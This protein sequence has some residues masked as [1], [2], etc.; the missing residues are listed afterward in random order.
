MQD[1]SPELLHLLLNV[2][3]TDLRVQL[4]KVLKEEEKS[5]TLIS[6]IDSDINDMQLRNII[7]YLSSIGLVRTYINDHPRTVSITSKGKEILS[8]L[9]K[10]N[11]LIW[12]INWVKQRINF[13]K[14][15]EDGPKT[16]K[17]IHLKT[18]IPNTTL[19]ETKDYFLER[20]II[21]LSG[22][23]LIKVALTQQGKEILKVIK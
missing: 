15:L 13:I 3:W 14:C 1:I 10:E 16:I 7:N 11:I 21:K 19:Y 6:K 9:N 12:Q 8:F 4:L 23:D 20:G 22:K 18:K 2:E 17:E 5:K